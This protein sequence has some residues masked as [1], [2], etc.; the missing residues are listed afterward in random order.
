MVSNNQKVLRSPINTTPRRG[1]MVILVLVCLVIVFVGAA[2]AIDVAYMH[3]TRAELR[4]AT[5]A[6]S[7][8]GAET[9]G[10]TQDMNAAI[11]A[12]IDTAARNTVAA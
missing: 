12:A 8:A 2:F 11:Q 6:A 3:S 7:R 5:D 9:L 10:R 1:A 4:T